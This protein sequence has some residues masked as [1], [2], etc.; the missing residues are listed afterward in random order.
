MV[1]KGIVFDL[2][3]TIINSEVLQY[4]AFNKYLQ[5]HDEAYSISWEDWRTKYI[6]RLSPDIM[7]DLLKQFSIN[8]SLDAAQRDRRLYYQEMVEN[9]QLEVMHGFPEFFEW[10]KSLDLPYMIITNSHPTGV[11]L[12]LRS[13]GLWGEI[14]ILTSNDTVHHKPDPRAFIEASKLINVVPDECL[15]I[16]DHPDNIKSAKKLGAVTIAIN[17]ESNGI[18]AFSEADLIV[19]NYLDPR[20]RTFISN[21]L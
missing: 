3:G 13:I 1:I 5:N 4:K 10:I 20:L 14:A 15:I 19:E 11:E 7:N 6:G 9:G 17:T 21:R 8:V 12:S 16:E 18:H 2:D